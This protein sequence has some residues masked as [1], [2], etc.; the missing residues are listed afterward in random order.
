MNSKPV[1]APPV[2][3]NGILINRDGSNVGPYSEAQVA[4]MVRDG[5]LSPMDLAWRDGLAA[6]KPL[7][8]LEISGCIPPLPTNQ[9]PVQN[10]SMD[11]PLLQTLRLQSRM[12]SRGVAAL[13][14]I[15][16]PFIGCFYA[17][18]ACGIVSTAFGALFVWAYL[19]PVVEGDLDPF[20]LLLSLATYLVSIFAAISLTGRYNSK[21]LAT[22]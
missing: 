20:W 11:N 3:K 10:G 16:L 5:I 18:V 14:S 17:S 7:F 12:K 9:P 1:V 4:G 19:N 8:S 15:L 22:A 2:V 6:W 13:L 21:L